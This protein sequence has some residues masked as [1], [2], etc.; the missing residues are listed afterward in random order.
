MVAA[1][2][3]PIRMGFHDRDVGIGSRAG[4][5]PKRNRV[6]LVGSYRQAGLIELDVPRYRVSIGHIDSRRRLCAG[7][8]KSSREAGMGVVV[9]L[10]YPGGQAVAE[11]A[12]AHQIRSQRLVDDLPGR[13]HCRVIGVPRHQPRVPPGLQVGRVPG[14]QPIQAAIEPFLNHTVFVDD[15]HKA[16]RRVFGQWQTGKPVC[17]C[18]QLCRVILLERHRRVVEKAQDMRIF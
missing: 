16:H 11:S 7:K 4:L 1:Q 17:R 13:Q 6:R 14:R 8:I 3:R 10:A 5:G 12:V 15:F 18:Q 9:L 2:A